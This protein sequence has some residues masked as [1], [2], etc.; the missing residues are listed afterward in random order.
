MRRSLV[1]CS[2]HPPSHPPTEASECAISSANFQA[3]TPL[4][5]EEVAAHDPNAGYPGTEVAQPQAG[6][7]LMSSCNYTLDDPSALLA[8]SGRYDYAPWSNEAF[9]IDNFAP[10]ETYQAFPLDN[11]TGVQR[12]MKYVNTQPFNPSALRT[13]SGLAHNGYLSWLAFET[14]DE[15]GP[16]S[17]D[18]LYLLSGEERESK[19]DGPDSVTELGPPRPLQPQGGMNQEI[20]YMNLWDTQCL[21]TLHPAFRRYSI[22][23]KLPSVVFEATMALSACYLSRSQPQRKPFG[24]SDIPGL[25]YRPEISHQTTSQTYYKSAMRKV[26]S[27]VENVEKPDINSTLAVI[28]L[29]CNLESSMGNFPA[30]DLHSG[31]VS[32]IIKA[33]Q[34][35]GEVNDSIRV[36]LL[37]AWLQARLLNWWRRFHFSTL[38]F[39]KRRLPVS[40]QSEL[41]IRLSNEENRRVLVMLILCESLNLTTMALIK[42]W[43][44][45][46][47]TTVR[48]NE[49]VDDQLGHGAA[50]T[51]PP[52][53]DESQHSESKNMLEIQAKRL[54]EWHLQLPTTE[55]PIE[56]FHDARPEMLRDNSLLSTR[57]LLFSSHNAAMNYAYYVSARAI[58]SSA[59]FTSPTTPG[60]HNDETE[61]WIS[62]LIR[63]AAGIG[64]GKCVRYNVHTI[65]ISGLLLACSLR[66]RSLRFGL[67]IEDWLE[68]RQRVA[69]LEEGSFPVLQ[70]LRILR[71]IN[72]ERGQGQDALTLFQ[73][74]DDGGGLGKFDSY[75]S[76]AISSIMVYE[77]C[78]ITGCL[79][80][81]ITPV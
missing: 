6:Y 50:A 64:W 7:V 38:E 8:G 2:G 29:F 49:P 27:W 47:D 72:Q 39:Q 12:S 53:K 57:P 74:A 73:T 11:V 41:K 70:I 15:S 48:R 10:L 28:I 66:S 77:K 32:S 62:I 69:G 35:T 52:S 16:Q 75:N 58:Q 9:S 51:Q 42:S 81:K 34:D 20:F 71:I 24:V 78:E 80:T 21:A 14:M 63:I 23:D 18:N 46:Q 3:K 1:G 79:T 40:I 68:E 55:L 5:A 33:Q 56:S 65:G 17:S 4:Y 44:A 67:W 60:K 26:A 25:S 36:E 13:K 43:E 54:S 22:L 19:E 30:F 61:F 37:A 45:S 76:Q 31:G 59:D